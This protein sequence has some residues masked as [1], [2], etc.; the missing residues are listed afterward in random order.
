ME[1]NEIK[2]SSQIRMTPYVNSNGSKRKL[3]V[4]TALAVKNDNKDSVQIEL[5]QKNK[6]L[7]VFVNGKDLSYYDDVITVNIRVFSDNIIL[8]Y[9]DIITF[10]IKPNKNYNALLVFVTVSNEY[11]GKTRSIR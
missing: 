4:I 7:D 10:A 5:N 2:F 1:I 6:K 9:F 11:K 3:S 8:E